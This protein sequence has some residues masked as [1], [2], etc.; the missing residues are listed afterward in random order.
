MIG[1]KQ[2]PDTGLRGMVSNSE[3]ERKRREGKSHV[4]KNRE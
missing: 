3:R 1:P 4:E 2:M